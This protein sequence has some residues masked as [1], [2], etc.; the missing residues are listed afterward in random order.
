MPVLTYPFVTVRPGDIA[1]PYLPVIISNPDLKKT[2]T[3][4]ALIDTG[5][6]ECALPASFAPVLGHRLEAGK[7]KKINTGNGITTAYG[8]SSTI[9]LDGFS[10]G[11]VTIDY[12]PN[13]PTPL[14][15]YQSFLSRFI[16]NVNYPDK[17]FSLE[18]PD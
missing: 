3:V 4:Y 7:E 6:D 18:Y 9:E 10:T 17:I 15:G 5:A 12:M 1:R 13:L 14:L 8:H 16:L 2:I 11:L